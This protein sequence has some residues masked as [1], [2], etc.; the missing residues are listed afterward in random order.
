MVSA[1]HVSPG[2]LGKEE[3][4]REAR[5][6]RT[7]VRLARVYGRM[8][9]LLESQVKAHG[10]T[11]GQFDV[12][13]HIARTEGLNQQELADQLL[14]T[15]GNISHLVDRLECAGLVERRTTRGRANHLYSTAAGRDVLVKIIPPHNAAIMAMFSCVSD[16]ALVSLHTTLR[17][18]DL[19]L[20]SSLK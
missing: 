20:E 13:T 6:I 11:L 8:L 1:M 5:S 9:R 16:D 10:L 14:V 7:W 18:L 12:L 17:D 3:L 2:Q 19:Q 15:K 4:G